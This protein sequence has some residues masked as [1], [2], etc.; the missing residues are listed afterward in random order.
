M[1]QLV[2]N[3]KITI[4]LM[5]SWKMEVAANVYLVLPHWYNIANQQT[6]SAVHGSLGT[7]LTQP[8]RR[9][10]R[11]KIDQLKRTCTEIYDGVTEIERANDRGLDRNREKTIQEESNKSLK[12]NILY[13]K[14]KTLMDRLRNQEVR[15]SQ[16]NDETLPMHDIFDAD[17][18]HLRTML[19]NAN[20]KLI[21]LQAS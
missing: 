14:C 19:E 10:V 20:L 17:L 9:A 18:A 12:L 2:S 1:D 3:T 8:R 13:H 21:S 7:H 5:E 6:P 16:F 15:L 11:E 4:T